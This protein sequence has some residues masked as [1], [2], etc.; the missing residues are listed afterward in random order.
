MRPIDADDLQ[1]AMEFVTN[2]PT[3]PMH[4]AATIAQIIDCAPIV[5][6]SAV[7]GEWSEKQV[8]YK[9]T[10]GNLHAGYRQRCNCSGHERSPELNTAI[11]YP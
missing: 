11:T 1:K 8:A 5:D 3:C 4:I 9:D 7:R 2:D 10:F 6:L